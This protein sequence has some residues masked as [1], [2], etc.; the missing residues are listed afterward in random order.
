[1]F[2]CFVLRSILCNFATKYNYL[3]PMKRFLMMALVMLTSCSLAWSIPARPGKVKVTQPDGTQL[4]IELHGDEY[5][6][7]T[8]TAD[9]Y[10]V[11]KAADGFYYYAVKNQTELLPSQFI[12]RDAEHRTAAENLYLSTTKKHIMA[13]MTA[14]QKEFQQRGRSLWGKPMLK[15]PANAPAKARYDYSKF[16]GLIVLIEWSDRSFA[17]ENTKELFEQM[18]NQAGYTGYQDDLLNQYV[19]CTG[20]VTDYFSDNSEQIFQPQ[21]DIVGPVKVNY[22][23]TYP[24]GGKN[25]YPVINSAFQQLDPD[26][27]FADYDVDKD[28]RVDMVYFIFAGYA[29]SSEGNDSRYVW[30]H[31]S[32]LAYYS[33]LRYDNKRFGRYACSTE[34]DGF[35]A[36][37]QVDLCGIGTIC[38]EFSHVLGLA[39]HYDADYEDGGGQSYDP[40]SWDVMANGSHNYNSRTPAGYNAYEK[41]TLGFMPAPEVLDMEGQSY[42]LEALNTSNK[43]YRINT[44]QNKEFFLIENRQNT[45]WDAALPGHGMLVWRVDSTDV[46]I[47]NANEVN[48]FPDH[49]YFELVRATPSGGDSQGDPYPGS[50]KVEDLTNDTEPGSLLTW[51]GYRSDITLTKIKE[52]DG[53]IYFR[54]AGPDELALV[55][56]FELIGA[57][58]GN[59][60]GVE[61]VFC[62]WDMDKVEIVPTQDTF[63]VENQ[64]LA[65]NRSGIIT[66]SAI[67]SPIRYV[68]F[69][70]WNS[71]KK[72]VQ[73][74]FS[75]MNPGET[76]WTTVKEV[77]S[78][79]NSLKL[80]KNEIVTLRY[81]LNSKS[82]TRFRFQYLSSVNNTV[83]YVDNIK[84]VLEDP[85]SIATGIVDVNHETPTDER[86][87]NLN[88]QRVSPDTKGIIIRNGKKYLN[89]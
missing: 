52:N 57:G 73:I 63:G 4:T 26:V 7:F 71:S 87:Y 47:W 37:N 8:T 74:T 78:N 38:H 46:S 19:S 70:A 24:N 34:F 28:G 27:N 31:A 39:D 15:A 56:T 11:V 40:G 14:E 80:D 77:T 25:L 45:R 13:D 69:K 43:A 58:T 65:M 21:F 30:P 1:M 2:I 16:K 20:S 62:N 55:E 59:T 86:C 54:T 18:V 3:E 33:S 89:K 66:S 68:T 36:N 82:G 75:V 49:N 29:S 84:V 12:A 41:F 17:R 32:T 76:K 53:T 50:G 85:S 67:N 22:T 83:C 10:T 23:C 9:G 88:G 79:T 61:G 48:N 72:Q 60:N 44:K 42:S 6:H 51:A 5:R 81:P 64:M 35:E